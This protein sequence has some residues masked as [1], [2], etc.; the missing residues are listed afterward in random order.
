MRVIVPNENKNTTTMLTNVTIK[1]L[2]NSHGSQ[3]SA[4]EEKKNQQ[5]LAN[6]KTNGSN[7]LYDDFVIVRTNVCILDENC[8][9]LA[10][11]IRK[12]WLMVGNVLM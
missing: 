9:C 12:L 2:Q 7:I 6:N 4:G 5:Q 1:K 3:R 8:E 10:T 11:V